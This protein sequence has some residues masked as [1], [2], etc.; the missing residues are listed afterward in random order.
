MGVLLNS[1]QQRSL[2][3]G[4]GDLY[5]RVNLSD[6]KGEHDSRIRNHW[7]GWRVQY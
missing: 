2:T 4:L 7:L 3:G 6:A 1:D 5:L